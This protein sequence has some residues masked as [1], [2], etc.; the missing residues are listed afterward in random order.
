MTFN[1]RTGLGRLAIASIIIVAC[2]GLGIRLL[3]KK[4]NESECESKSQAGPPSSQS[5]PISKTPE[6]TGNTTIDGRTASGSG[7]VHDKMNSTAKEQ[8]EASKAASIR[9]TIRAI[10]DAAV[11][12]NTR[13]AESLT[14]GLKRDKEI[15]KQILIEAIQQESD[16]NMRIF[17]MD[18]LQR[19]G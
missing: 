7:G 5:R 8:A 10:R 12:N 3:S 1:L 16:D 4:A 17:L 6:T 13:V 11:R 19:L 2:I 14:A 9:N 18:L 15:S